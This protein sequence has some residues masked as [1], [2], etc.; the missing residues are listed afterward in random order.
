[1]GPRNGPMS[2]ASTPTPSPTRRR[3]RSPALGRSPYS[4]PASPGLGRETEAEEGGTGHGAGDTTA[5]PAPPTTAGFPFRL[6]EHRA[7]ST[8]ELPEII[9]QATLEA[10]LERLGRSAAASASA[11]QCRLRAR[12]ATQRVQG[13]RRT[14]LLAGAAP[15]PSLHWLHCRP[16]SQTQMLQPPHSLYWVRSRPCS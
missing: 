3:A 14:A 16:C 1:M 13:V 10:A 5:P 7:A 9:S 8:I 12:A 2:P 15:P 4:N 6:P 11:G